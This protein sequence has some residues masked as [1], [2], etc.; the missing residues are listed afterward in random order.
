MDKLVYDVTEVAKLLGLSRP[1]VYTIL[2]RAENKLPSFRVG[3]RRKI[4]RTALEAWIA[5]QEVNHAA[6]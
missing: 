1:T 2:D 5:E 6:G 4:S 3:N